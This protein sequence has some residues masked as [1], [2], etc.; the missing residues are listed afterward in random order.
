MLTFSISQGGVALESTVCICSASNIVCCISKS[1]AS[2]AL[3][4]SSGCRDYF[5]GDSGMEQRSKTS[6]KELF[7]KGALKK[8]GTEGKVR[9]STVL[10]TKHVYAPKHGYHALADDSFLQGRSNASLSQPRHNQAGLA[11]RSQVLDKGKHVTHNHGMHTCPAAAS[12][13]QGPNARALWL[14][15]SAI[16]KLI[17]AAGPSSTRS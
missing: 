9:P 4:G 7:G 16:N 2:P 13:W 14:S 5:R 12:G 11:C 6:M 8:D 1:R 10:S 15:A 17:C 3:M